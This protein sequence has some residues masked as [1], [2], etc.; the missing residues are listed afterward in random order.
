MKLQFASGDT[1]PEDEDDDPTERFERPS[2]A[3]LVGLTSEVKI[4]CALRVEHMAAAQK[5]RAR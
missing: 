3:E 4:R 1:G 5:R 2:M